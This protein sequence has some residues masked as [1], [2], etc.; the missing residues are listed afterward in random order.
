MPH[1]LHAAVPSAAPIGEGSVRHVVTPMRA[2]PCCNV[3]RRMGVSYTIDESYNTGAF[4]SYRS[5]LLPLEA[6][7]QLECARYSV[8]ARPLRMSAATGSVVCSL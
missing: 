8:G 3:A 5:H 7:A 6:A 4:N 1:E 2:A